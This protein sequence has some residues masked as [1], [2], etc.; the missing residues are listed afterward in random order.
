MLSMGTAIMAIGATIL[1][2]LLVVGALT[3]DD[4]VGFCANVW[5]SIQAHF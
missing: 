2:T 4:V 5:H 1:V 3:I